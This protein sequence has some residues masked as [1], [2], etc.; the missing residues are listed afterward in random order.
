MQHNKL[1]EGSE[2]N[3]TNN[4]YCIFSEFEPKTINYDC[5]T[6]IESKTYSCNSNPK[7]YVNGS[8]ILTDIIS[9][10][11][12]LKDCPYCYLKYGEN[13]IVKHVSLHESQFNLF[14]ENLCEQK[15][16]LTVD[17]VD[18]VYDVDKNRV[19]ANVIND[20]P[21]YDEI[22]DPAEGFELAVKSGVNVEDEDYLIKQLEKST[23]ELINKKSKVNIKT[24]KSSQSLN[25]INKENKE[26]NKKAEIK[27]T[28]TA[29]R[30]I[31]FIFEVLGM[32]IS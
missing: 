24:Q 22:V 2:A 27:K 32:I 29:I 30:V 21:N 16:I 26:I 9:K 1:S 19:L 18:D 25:K 12:I 28:Y 7:I 3:I 5:L 8:N 6:D 13:E 23:T 4:T 15:S 17:K 10:D 14:E 31:G 11:I 20:L